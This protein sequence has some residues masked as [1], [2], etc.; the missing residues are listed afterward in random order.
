MNVLPALRDELQKLFPEYPMTFISLDFG[1]EV[2]QIKL[3]ENY[4][5]SLVQDDSILKVALRGIYAHDA[6]DLCDPNFIDR[7]V[8]LIRS[9]SQQIAVLLANRTVEPRL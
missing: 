3:D 8:W 7:I 5:L 6:I 1:T 4:Y 9:Y 2:L